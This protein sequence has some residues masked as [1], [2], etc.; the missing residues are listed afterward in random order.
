MHVKTQQDKKHFEEQ[1]AKGINTNNI[2]SHQRFRSLSENLRGQLTVQKNIIAD[3]AILKLFIYIS[4]Y[5][6]TKS[7]LRWFQPLLGVGN[8]RKG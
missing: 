1:M 4:A 3:V 5:S 2:S 6:G 7:V 8:L